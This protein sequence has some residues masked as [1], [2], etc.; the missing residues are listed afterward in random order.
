MFLTD[1]YQTFVFSVA[2]CWS[3]LIENTFT[4]IAREQTYRNYYTIAND[5]YTK[6]T[7]LEDYSPKQEWLFSDVLRFQVR[8]A[9]RA[10]GFISDD[11]MTWNNYNGLSQNSSFYEKYLGVKINVVS[12][13][14]YQ[15]IV[16]SDEFK[17]MP[18]YP[19]YGSIKII[20]DVVV[21]KVSDKTL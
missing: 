5:I 21:I 13:D 8:D 10:N 3:F 19:N 12:K 18:I 15:E 9:S 14:I 7:S 11:N 1:F 2:L 20:D 6:V 17:A 4:Y 16:Q